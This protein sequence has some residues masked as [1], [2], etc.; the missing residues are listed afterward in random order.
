[1]KKTSLLN[2]ALSHTIAKLGHGDIL[3]IADAGLPVPPG[4]QCIDLALTANIPRFEDVLRVVLSEMQVE[5]ATLAKEIETA[6]P[7]VLVQAKSLLTC[8]T[9]YLS[10]QDFKVLCENARAIVR[11]GEFSP[12]ANVALHAGA[13]F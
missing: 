10:H 3:V 9:Q 1:M 7:L 12:Y 6:N 8:P 4:V 11:T 5:S 2:A 13:V